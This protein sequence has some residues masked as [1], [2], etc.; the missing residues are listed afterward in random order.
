M[1]ENLNSNRTHQSVQLVPFDAEFLKCS[2]KWLRDPEIAFLTGT[3]EITRESQLVF[4]N[5]LPN[6]K[7]Y[8]IWGVN[9][10]NERAGA[11]GIK[12]IDSLTG[13]YWGYIGN[14]SLWGKGHGSVLC[15]ELIARARKMELHSLYLKVLRTNS[16]AYSLYAKMGFEEEVEKNGWVKMSLA[17]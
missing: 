7:D 9:I 12:N 3:G 17:L 8:K 5:S 16:R 1:M 10:D 13:E 11:A 15:R 2:Y 14:K 4:F 6:R